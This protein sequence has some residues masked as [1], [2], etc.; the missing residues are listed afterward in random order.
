MQL[1]VQ[2]YSVRD[3]IEA[4]LPGTI[5]RLA[6]IGFEHAEPYDFVARAGEFEAAFAASG[7]TAPSGHAPLLSSDQSAVF[8]AANRLGIGIVIDPFIPAEQWKSLDDV[9]RIA[10]QLNEAATAGAEHDVRVGYHNHWWE[11]ET[12]IDGST[13]LELLA[14][15]L[16]PQVVLEVDAYW[17]AVGG[18]DPVELLQRLG[19]QVRLVHLKDG[20]ITNDTQ[21]QQPAGEGRMP[22]ADI[23][24]AAPQLEVGVVEF[25]AYAGDIFDGVAASRTFLLPLVG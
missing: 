8:A 21:A 25:D 16:D 19:D 23:I 13:A 9:E 2:L 20:P 5:A 6:E 15:R 12:M 14:D 24:A 7:I 17:A 22:L 3:A 18:Q 10:G 11:L 1:S 4:D